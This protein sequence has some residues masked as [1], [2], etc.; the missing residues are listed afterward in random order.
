[1]SARLSPRL[2]WAALRF[3]AARREAYYDYLA[4]ILEATEGRKT[5]RQIFAHDSER[6]GA[7]AARGQ[8][9]AYWTFQIEE[10]GDVAQTFRGTLPDKEVSFISMMQR[11]GGGALAGGLRDLAALTRL[12]ARI[13]RILSSTLSMGVFALLLCLAA[14]IAIATFTAPT[15]LATFSQV[16]PLFYGAATKRLVAF[17]NW[18]GAWL[19]PLLALLTGAAFAL[20]QALPKWHGRARALLDRYAPGF[21]LYRDTQAIAFI[22]SLAA[23]LKPR[24][25]MHHSLAEALS[26]MSEHSPPWLKAHISGMALRLSDAQAGVT[27][28]KTGLLDAQTYWY[29]EDLSDALGMDAALQKTRQRLELATTSAVARRAGIMRW[30]MVGAALAF[31]LGVMFWHYAVIYEMRA[32][33]LLSY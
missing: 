27:V 14:M 9:S 26:M 18:L 25:G 33:L 11:M 24:G 30:L 7:R 28:F 6:Y 32:A 19:W 4:D 20:W 3:R 15:L 12:D 21:G 5:L 31:L 17:A 2:R 8:L 10:H 16:D 13:R 29:L 22:V 1:M 23:I